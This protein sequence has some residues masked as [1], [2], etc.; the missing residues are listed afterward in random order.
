MSY[1]LNNQGGRDDLKDLAGQA[2][3]L[4][5]GAVRKEDE[6]IRVL[7]GGVRI[8]WRREKSSGPLT[9]L[10]FPCIFINDLIYFIL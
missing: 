8:L 10:S 3:F 1:L 6:R 9:F 2:S 7:K 5:Q 4:V